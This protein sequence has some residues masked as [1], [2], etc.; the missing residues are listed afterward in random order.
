MPVEEKSCE[1]E[2]K[3]ETRTKQTATEKSLVIASDIP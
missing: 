2:T 1:A 3:V